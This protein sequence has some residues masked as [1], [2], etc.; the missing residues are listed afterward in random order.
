MDRFLAMMTLRLKKVQSTKMT[1]DQEVDCSISGADA[2][3]QKATPIWSNAMRAAYIHSFIDSQKMSGATGGIQGEKGTLFGVPY[4]AGSWQ[5]KLI[6]A[7][8]GPRDMI[9]GKFSGLYD[10]QGNAKR[11]RNDPV[12][13]AQDRS[14]VTTALRPAIPSPDEQRPHHRPISEPAPGH[15][16]V[17]CANG[18]VDQRHGIL[19]K[20]TTICVALKSLFI[21]NW[22]NLYH[23]VDK[24]F[25]WS[26]P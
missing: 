15:C 9:G 16:A 13:I 11:D 2:C 26:F 24:E 20:A 8:A 19:D 4:V 25:I 3:N 17:A 22:P 23:Q 18:F 12:K 5:D 7:F 6:E 21:K 10:E 1:M 14:W